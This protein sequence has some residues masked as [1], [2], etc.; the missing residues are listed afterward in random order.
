[1]ILITV[2]YYIFPFFMIKQ[3][4]K[5]IL[6]ILTSVKAQEEGKS[7]PEPQQPVPAVPVKVCIFGVIVI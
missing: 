6:A 7:N 4:L 3:F 2:W 5:N 1:M